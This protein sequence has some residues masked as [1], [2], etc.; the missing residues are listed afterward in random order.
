MTDTFMVVGF[1]RA[2][3]LA[4]FFSTIMSTVT[5]LNVAYT[6]ATFVAPINGHSIDYSKVSIPK[7]ELEE[8][9]ARGLERFGISSSILA[10]AWVYVYVCVFGIL[11]S[12]CIA[13][14]VKAYWASAKGDDFVAPIVGHSAMRGAPHD[15]IAAEVEATGLFDSPISSSKINNATALQIRTTCLFG[16]KNDHKINIYDLNEAYATIG[17]L[18]YIKNNPNSADIMSKSTSMY[19][20]VL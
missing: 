9:P 4:I 14:I 16:I 7:L 17:R 13:R 6:S 2:L 18:E 1:S 5:I 10:G 12:T 20:R 15:E 3:K 8:F 11:V 19:Y